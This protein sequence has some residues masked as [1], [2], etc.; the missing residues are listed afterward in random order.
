MV[1]N[2]NKLKMIIK[3]FHMKWCPLWGTKAC[4]MMWN[5]KYVFIGAVALLVICNW[6]F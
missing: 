1:I 3:D 6:I 4:P 2:M 5:K